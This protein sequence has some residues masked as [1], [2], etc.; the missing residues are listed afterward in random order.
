MDFISEFDY[1]SLMLLNSKEFY[2][3]LTNTFLFLILVV[4]FLAIFPLIVAIFIKKTDD[5]SPYKTIKYGKS[6]PDKKIKV[7][8]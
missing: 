3:S 8:F 1:S 2:T 5:L 6:V 4:P 7:K